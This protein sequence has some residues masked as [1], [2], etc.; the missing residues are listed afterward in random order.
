MNTMTWIGAL[1]SVLAVLPASRS[2]AQLAPL[3]QSVA[4]SHADSLAS[5][6]V[7]TE[8]TGDHVKALQLAEDAIKSDPNTPWG[9]YVKGDALGSLQRTEDAVS[10]FRD[11]EQHFSNAEVWGRS[12]AIWGQANAFFQA[13]RCDDAAGL[14]ERYAS[15][16][17]KID[18]E[19]AALARRFEKSCIPHVAAH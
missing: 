14:Y 7:Q 12:I 13:G 3:K 15:F 2:Y 17:E 11:A 5:Q 1:A 16:V 10:A 19:A 8:L 9:R 18:Q 4:P 6:S